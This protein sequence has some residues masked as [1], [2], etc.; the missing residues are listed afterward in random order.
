MSSDEQD[1]M[2][3]A[4][5]SMGIP[6]EED[7]VIQEVSVKR[8]IRQHHEGDCD[9]YGNSTSVTEIVGQQVTIVVYRSEN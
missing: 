5:H 3:V 1:A 7:W 9:V 2:R 8:D 4:L 6:V